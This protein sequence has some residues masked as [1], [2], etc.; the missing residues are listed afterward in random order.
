MDPLTDGPSLW[1]GL[2]FFAR[3]LQADLANFFLLQYRDVDGFLVTSK[4]SG[5]HWLKFMLSCAIAEQYGVPPPRRSSGHEADRIIGHPRWPQRAR[6]PR[7][8]SS[9]TIPSIAFTWTWL[10]WE[11]PHPPVVVLVRD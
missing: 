4:N 8:G 6:V 3:V 2:Q 9:Y 5:T 10:V 1:Q 11:M 7:I